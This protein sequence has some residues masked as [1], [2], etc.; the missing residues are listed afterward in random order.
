M[1]NLGRFLHRVGKSIVI[2]VEDPR[3]IPKIGAPLL[4]SNGKRVAIVAD[5]IGNVRSPYV[6]A[7]GEETPLYFIQKR[8]LLRGDVDG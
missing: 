6:V 4:D 7:K 1:K 3:W 2:R 8:F 5:V